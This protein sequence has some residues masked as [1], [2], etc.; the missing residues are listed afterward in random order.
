MCGL[1]TF[2]NNYAFV[3]KTSLAKKGG[4]LIGFDFTPSF[5]IAYFIYRWVVK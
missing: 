1:S 2:L 5:N 3:V 4:W